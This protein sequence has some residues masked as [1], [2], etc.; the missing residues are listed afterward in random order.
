LLLKEIFM[1]KYISASVFSIF[2]LF[3]A[4][5]AEASCGA[6]FCPINT[7][8][9]T[10]GVWTEPGWR[11]DLRYEYI[12]QNQPRSGS[13]AISVGEIPHHHDEVKT[14]NRNM[15]ATMEYSFANSWGVTASLPVADRNHIH[16]HN[17]GG[18][19]LLEQWDFTEI[20]DVQVMG[21]YQ[22][23][24][25]NQPYVFG[26]YF[27]AKLPTGKFDVKNDDGDLAERSLQ[28]GTG[29][30]D[31]LLGFYIR[32]NF[33]QYKTSVFA[34]AIAQLPLNE[35]DEYR[36]GEKLSV[37]FGARYDMTRRLSLML[38]FNGQYK[39]KDSG[40]NA[41][42]DDSGGYTISLSPG[43]SYGL[44]EA[45]QIYGFVQK[46]LYQHV[47]GVQLTPDWSAVT[48][49]SLHF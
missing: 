39:W 46:P 2:T 33:L 22:F 49:I 3:A 37:D 9:N 20:G 47:N 1:P 29:T 4:S 8:W 41:E 45:A 34:Q 18:G 5:S 6:A 14:I 23:N 24:G 38:Q 11:A 27:G 7:Q 31:A 26:V 40:L 48:G 36:P 35:R 21:R 13:D 10:Q 15:L 25:W 42:P 19:Q 32:E 28:P 12:P 17:H 16:I 30:T 43:I 44:T